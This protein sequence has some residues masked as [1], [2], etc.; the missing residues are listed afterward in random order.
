MKSA[1]SRGLLEHFFMLSTGSG[2][3]SGCR[4]GNGTWHAQLVLRPMSQMGQTR[5]NSACANVFRVILESGHRSIQSAR[6]KS[7]IHIGSQ[8]TYIPALGAQAISVLVLVQP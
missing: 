3:F 5:K 6:L 4:A 2:D 8:S 7:A 1:P